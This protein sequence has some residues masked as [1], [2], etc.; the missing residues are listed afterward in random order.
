M[1]T[2][3]KQYNEGMMNFDSGQWACHWNIKL[4]SGPFSFTDHEYQIEPMTSQVRRKCV[5]KGTQGGFTEAEVLDSLH[6]MRYGLLPQGVLYLFP[7]TDDVGEFAKSRFNPLI[8]ANKSAIGKYVKSQGKG[9]D[10]AS[11]KKINEAFLY[12]RGARL[13]QKVSDIN[14]SSKLRSI[15]VDRV[16][17]DEI[18]LMDPDVVGKARGRMGHSK[19]KQERYLSNPLVP[20][21]GIDE[22]FELSDQRYW[23][24]Q[25]Q[26]CNTKTCA[27]LYFL[28]DKEKCVGIRDNGTGFIS[29]RNCGQEVF[30]RDGEW[31]PQV[32]SNS[33]YMHGYQWSQLTSAFVDPVDILH[34]FLNP[35]KNNLADVYRLQLGLPYIADSDRLQE[36]QVFACCNNDGMVF[37]HNGPCAMGVDV[38]EIK[39]VVIGTRTGN[40]QYEIVRIAQF[41]GLGAWNEIHDLA[42]RFNVKSAVIDIRPDTDIVRQFQKA[43]PYV[44]YLCEYS[45]NAAYSRTWDTKRYVVKDY[46]TALFDETHR[47]VVTPGMLTIPR[48]SEPEVKEFAKQMANA[49]KI[50]ETN[51]RTGAKAYRYRGK[52]EHYRNAMNYFLLAASGHRVGTVSRYKTNQYAE[53]D[54]EYD[55]M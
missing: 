36:S 38:G 22:I 26:H 1:V 21:E 48:G 13:S 16:V 18:D 44:I 23:F 32:P 20:G 15:P 46:R 27:E 28:E 53:V 33:D 8:L 40:D 47:M 41:S 54:N 45:D 30:I 4:Q 11:L 55:R 24:R 7:T 25:C 14:E 31:V 29:C 12:L 35:P 52:K 5:R 19:I 17:F 43:E 3:A 34:D 2:D 51:K 10:T 39:H 37:S 42:R 49:Y 6:G 9:T 50:L